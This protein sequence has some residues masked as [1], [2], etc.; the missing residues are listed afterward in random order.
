MPTCSIAMLL[1]ILVRGCLL[2]LLD[3]PQ[4]LLEL[5]LFVEDEVPLLPLISYNIKYN[6]VHYF[7]AIQQNYY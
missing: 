6:V 4:A 2:E 7:L 3:A 1:S 5:L